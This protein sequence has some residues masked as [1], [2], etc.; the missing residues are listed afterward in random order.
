L[1]LLPP[2]SCLSVV[3]HIVF[4]PAALYSHI[5]LP[6]VTEATV[7]PIFS[8]LSTFEIVWHLGIYSFILFI[9]L[10]LPW[11]ISLPLPPYPVYFIWLN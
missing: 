5:Y 10:L 9:H 1:P 11:P 6:L 8:P 3:F 2:T 4:I 7:T